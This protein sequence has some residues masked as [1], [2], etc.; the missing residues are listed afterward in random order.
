VYRRLK[1]RI[2][3]KK[4]EKSIELTNNSGSD[5]QSEM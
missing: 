3:E 2:K 4:R 1:N 5:G